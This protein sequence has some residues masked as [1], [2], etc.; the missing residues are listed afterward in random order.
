MKQTAGFI[1]TY[2]AD[3]FGVCSALFELGGMTVMHDASGCNSTY[4]THDEPRWYDMDSLVFISALTEMEAV[5]GDDGRLVREIVDAAK[6]LNPKFIAVAGTPIPMMTGTDFAAVARL[7]EEQTGILS[8]GFAT[9]GMRPYSSGVGM[10]F[11]ALARRITDRTAVKTQGFSA[12]I[13]GLTP[14]DFSYEPGDALSF[15]AV[16]CS[17]PYS[18]GRC[19]EAHLNGSAG[20]LKK[21]LSAHGF[22]LIGSWAMGGTLDEIRQAGRARVNLVVSEGGLPAAR[23]LRELY[24]TPYVAGLP[25]GGRVSE[26]LFADLAAA[27]QTGECTV[28]YEGRD[29]PGI[30]DIAVIGES[31]SAGSLVRAIEQE[32]GRAARAICPLGPDP[33]LLPPGGVRVSDEDDIRGCLSAFRAVIADPLYRPVCPPSCRLI[34][35]P[36]EAFSGRIYRNRIPDLISGFDGWFEQIKEEFVK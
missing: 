13:I 27:A 2:S 22:E 21:Q 19:G 3:V 10:A 6:E 15:A 4:N 25:Y 16:P 29:W 18:A 26:K 34:E 35:L 28:S 23:A 5:M 32:T 36:H 17:A 24:G 11:E 30:P 33:E 20:S 9:N 1:S 14:L 12:N 8:F 31:V 7:V